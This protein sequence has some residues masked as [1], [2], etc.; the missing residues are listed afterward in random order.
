MERTKSSI[1]NLIYAFTGQGAGI[2]ISVL[3]RLVFVKVLTAEYLGL[4]GLFSNILSM[5]SLVEL[6]VGPAMTFSLYKPLAEKNAEKIKSLMNLYKNTYRVI[7][8]VMLIIGISITPFL[9]YLIDEMP[10]ISNINVIYIFFVIN[11]SISYFYSYKRSLIISDQKSYLATLYRYACYFILN[12]IQIVVLII[13]KNYELYLI[14]QILMTFTENVIVSK[15]ADKLYPYLRE[16]NI[17]KLSKEDTNPIKKNITA[18]VA[19]KV[20]GIVVNSTDN[21]IISKFVGLVAVG[22]YSNYYLITN[23]L[24]TVCT[25][26]FTSITASVGNLCATESKEKIYEIFEKTLFINFWIYGFA[27]ICLF[28]LFNNFIEIWVGKEYLF[29]IGVVSIIIINFYI[30]GMRKTVLT[31][32][33]ALGLY[34]QDRYKPIIESVINIIASLILVENYGVLGVFIGTLISTLTTCFWLEPYIL[35][36]YGIKNNVKKYFSK[37]AIYTFITIVAGCITVMISEFIFYNVNIINFVGKM[38]ICTIIPNLFFFMAFHKSKEFIY[39]KDL[40][41]N[42]VKKVIQRKNKKEKGM[43]IS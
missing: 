6:G 2:I 19:H 4:N 40:A 18:M 36:K 30:S 22:I 21:L 9:P 43:S 24:N 7:G 28:V 29:S 5:L 42:L 33:D 1:K 25:Q 27:S 10:D 17:K 11:T 41:I 31:F 16:K 26:I 35:Y 14:A 23:A 32:R 37:Y 34:W 20:G 15:K 38:I 12:V 13:T 3:A 39:F 8:C